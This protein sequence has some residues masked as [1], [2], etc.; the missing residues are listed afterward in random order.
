MCL[1][2]YQDFDMEHCVLRALISQQSEVLDPAVNI[3]DSEVNV[4]MLAD[5]PE[6][7]R[8]ISWGQA[9]PRAQLFTTIRFNST[10][11]FSSPSFRCPSGE[12]TTLEFACSLDPGPC[13]V[14]FWQDLSSPSRGEGHAIQ[15]IH[16]RLLTLR[17]I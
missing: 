14:D 6:L 16:D 12:F 4:W 13:S 17:L 15:R 2:L 9:P 11:D 8:T 7:R 10:T 1:L 3:T 5:S